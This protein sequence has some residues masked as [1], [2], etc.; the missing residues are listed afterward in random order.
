MGKLGA[1]WQLFMVPVTR[2]D[3]PWL[4][5]VYAKGVEASLAAMTEVIAGDAKPEEGHVLSLT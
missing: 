4:R 5:V 3:Q 1:A 2:P